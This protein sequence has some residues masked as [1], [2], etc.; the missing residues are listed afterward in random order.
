MGYEISDEERQ[1]RSD[2]AKAAFAAGKFGGPQPGSGRPKTKKSANELVS[3]RIAGIADQVFEA[4]ESGLD[5]ELAASVRVNTAKEML[6]IER[7][8]RELDLKEKSYEDMTAKE[9]Q[10]NLVEKLMRAVKSGNL[11]AGMF[12]ELESVE[13]PDEY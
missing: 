9:L 5:P 11:P 8:N 7:D 10:E 13:E 12:L 3:A 6:K 1:R 2:A 4:L